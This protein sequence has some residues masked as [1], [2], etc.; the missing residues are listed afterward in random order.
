MNRW[1][2]LAAVLFAS[3]AWAQEAKVPIP[4]VDRPLQIP[5]TGLA[6]LKLAWSAPAAWAG[7]T[8]GQ[9]GLGTLALVGLSLA[10]DRPVDRAVRRSD[11]S[12]Y[13][14]WA[15]R[16]DTLGGTGTIVIAGG[17]YLGG[18]LANQPKLREFGA[19]A[20]FSMLVAEVGFTLPAKY[21]VG[22]SRPFDDAGP[23]RF[24]P[25]NGGQSFP[26][27]HSTQAFTLAAVVS[28]YADNSLA[29]AAAYTGAALV[30]LARIEE[31]QH[32]LSDVTAGAVI[33]VLS[34][35]AV[36]LRHRKLRLGARGQAEITVAPVWTPQQTA[37]RVSVTF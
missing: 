33:G 18:L 32:Y 7:A 6:D 22:R 34:A 31:R 3:A 9:V 15:R 23:Y 24:K 1:V 14:P 2:S 28:A 19:D 26:S 5:A 17:S 16:L 29:S 37:L 13:D 30:G 10:L 11:L 8:W 21:L 20:S 12:A 4:Q 27:S 36:M 35:K 25:L